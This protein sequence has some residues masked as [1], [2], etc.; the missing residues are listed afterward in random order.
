MPIGGTLVMVNGVIIRRIADPRIQVSIKTNDRSIGTDIT[1]RNHI[2]RAANGGIFD[3]SRTNI[4]T[5][6]N[7]FKPT[8]SCRK[9]QSL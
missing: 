7:P 2:N 4:A 3:D 1:D 8:L 5:H 9:P 6:P